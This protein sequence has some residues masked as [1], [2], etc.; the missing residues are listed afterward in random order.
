[1]QQDDPVISAC[2]CSVVKLKPPAEWVFANK[3]HNFNA[4]VTRFLLPF[5]SLDRR[6]SPLLDQASLRTQ[7]H[8]DDGNRIPKLCAALFLWCPSH[9]RMLVTRVNV[10]RNVISKQKSE[11]KIIMHRIHFVS[12]TPNGESLRSV[13]TFFFARKVSRCG[14]ISRQVLCG[15]V[16]VK[17]SSCWQGTHR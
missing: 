14:R 1:M 11:T 12:F 13:N 7:N 10:K 16:E 15:R 6:R 17:D 2:K 5:H 4:F 8:D 3:I 9:H